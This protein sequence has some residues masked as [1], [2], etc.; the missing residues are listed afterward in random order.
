[1]GVVDTRQIRQSRMTF[2][3]RVRRVAYKTPSS[4]AVK[5]P[6]L[7]RGFPSKEKGM[8]N[9]RKRIKPLTHMSLMQ[10]FFKGNREN[11]KRMTAKK[12]PDINA[13][14]REQTAITKENAVIPMSFIL[15][16]RA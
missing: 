9:Q 14:Q 15:G 2:D 16:S 12:R 8:N 5:G 13:D 7:I 11:N 1:M 10:T 3:L 4:V 6:I